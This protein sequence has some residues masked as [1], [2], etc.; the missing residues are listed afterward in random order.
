MTAKSKSS[1][2][3]PKKPDLSGDITERIRR[4]SN[5]SAGAILI[6]MFGMDALFPRCA[7]DWLVI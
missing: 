6:F 3:R 4:R 2:P 5:A 7:T 1:E